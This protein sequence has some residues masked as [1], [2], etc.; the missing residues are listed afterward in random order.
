M[1]SE[2]MKVETEGIWGYNI[3]CI[4]MCI[5]DCVY[6]ISSVCKCVPGVFL[7]FK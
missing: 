5:Y 1:C 2:K 7:I 6:K 4:C 3:V